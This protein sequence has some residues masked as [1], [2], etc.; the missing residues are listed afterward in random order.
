MERA[1]DP[2]LIDEAER[3]LRQYCSELSLESISIFRKD[4]VLLYS[5]NPLIVLE[6]NAE[7]LFV[8][9][10]E[11]VCDF[12]VDV[13]TTIMVHDR[14]NC[15]ILRPIDMGNLEGWYLVFGR[16]SEMKCGE[17]SNNFKIFAER[18]RIG[19]LSA[20][21]DTEVNRFRLKTVFDFPRIIGREFEK[22]DDT[23]ITIDGKPG[24]I[25]QSYDS[26]PMGIKTIDP[27]IDHIYP[28]LLER[29]DYLDTFLQYETSGILLPDPQFYVRKKPTY[30]RSNRILMFLLV[31]GFAL[32]IAWF[33]DSFLDAILAYAFTHLILLFL[34]WVSK[35]GGEIRGEWTFI[36]CWYL[37]GIL[38]TVTVISQLITSG[39]IW[40]AHALVALMFCSYFLI[41]GILFTVIRWEREWVLNNIENDDEQETE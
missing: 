16:C 29:L 19:D 32:M 41:A 14:T 18:R 10:E 37:L 33:P 15:L 8:V 9:L 5:S 20:K 31:Y 13:P 4:G 21:L 25:I 24:F 39:D 2:E 11:L 7:Q 34:V 26:P 28:P 6:E 30:Y 35:G 27:P 17:L 23:V 3:I 36:C 40:W 12:V 1:T 22:N 38:M